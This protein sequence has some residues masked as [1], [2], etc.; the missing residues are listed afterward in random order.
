MPEEN[1]DDVISVD[2]ALTMRN[3]AIERAHDLTRLAKQAAILIEVANRHR[4][5]PAYTDWLE[6]Y[7]ILVTEGDQPPQGKRGAGGEA[8]R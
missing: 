8:E 4:P 3:T 5:D 1:Q 7:H 6:R 2:D